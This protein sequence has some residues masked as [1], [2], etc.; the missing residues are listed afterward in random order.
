MS[1]LFFDMHVSQALNK[2]RFRLFCRNDKMLIRTL[3]VQRIR[4]SFASSIASSWF[5]TFAFASFIPFQTHFE[6][7]SNGK[8]RQ[9]NDGK[10]Y[11]DLKMN[12]WIYLKFP[13]I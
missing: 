1:A 8:Y 13:T 11:F 6:V 2:I 5:F 9:P 3:N 7:D 12:I 10:T 4:F